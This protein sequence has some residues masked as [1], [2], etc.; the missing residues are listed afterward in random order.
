MYQPKQGE[1]M[2]IYNVITIDRK[3]GDQE[4][5]DFIIHLYPGEVIDNQVEQ[6]TAKTAVLFK[7]IEG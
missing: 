7:K 6:S 3:T 2:S 4:T 5:L 1:T